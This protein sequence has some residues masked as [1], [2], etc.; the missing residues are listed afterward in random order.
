MAH[1]EKGIAIATAM[2]MISTATYH[3]C[4]LPVSWGVRTVVSSTVFTISAP[5]QMRQIIAMIND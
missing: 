5:K 4:M 2:M 3:K 1:E